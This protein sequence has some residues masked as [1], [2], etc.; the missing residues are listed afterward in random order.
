[1]AAYEFFSIS[2]CRFRNLSNGKVG[3]FYTIDCN[4]WVQIVAE[5]ADGKI[6]MVSQYR[7]G[8]QKLSLE[9][10]GGIMERGEDVIIAARREL[11]EE[12]GFCGDSAKV[13]ATHYPNPAVQTNVV[14]VV[15][16]KNCS[17]TRNTNFDEFEDLTTSLVTKQNLVNKITDGQ[18]NHSI[19][20]SAIMKYILITFPSPG[21]L[22]PR[23]T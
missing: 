10:P 3:N 8:S 1:L 23:N 4:D 17:K 14:N 16:I 2:R 15:L 18:I 7:F 12:T 5:T 19:T 20:L 6:I 11:E 9:L 22:G 13:I 21:S